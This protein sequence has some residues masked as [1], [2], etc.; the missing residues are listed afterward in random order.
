MNIVY[1]SNA[2]DVIA[3]VQPPESYMPRQ[4]SEHAKS[5]TTVSKHRAV[6]MK[7]CPT[8][9]RVITTRVKGGGN[10]IAVIE[11]DTRDLT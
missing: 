6:A 7:Y 2:D 8:G 10:L 4:T 3:E 9:W 1:I 5:V 11:V